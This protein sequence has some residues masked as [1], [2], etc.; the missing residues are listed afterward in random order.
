MPHNLQIVDYRLGHPG[1]VYNAYV[2]QGNWMVKDHKGLI[3]Q[4]HWICVDGA[5]PTQ[6][7]VSCHSRQSGGDNKYLSK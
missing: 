1:S 3:P 4:N 5:Y 6:I 7:G 2:F